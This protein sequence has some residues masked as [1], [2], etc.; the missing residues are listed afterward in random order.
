MTIDSIIMLVIYAILIAVLLIPKTK[1][2][3]RSHREF[4]EGV[5]YTFLVIWFTRIIL[6]GNKIPNVLKSMKTNGLY[7][8]LLIFYIIVPLFFLYKAIQKFT[9]HYKLLQEQK[10]IEEK[11][12]EKE[13]S[14]QLKTKKKSKKKR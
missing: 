8:F 1:N 11:K 9:E 14:K 3:L 7:L 13:A 5:L 4:T 10:E 12:K 2:Y 6:T